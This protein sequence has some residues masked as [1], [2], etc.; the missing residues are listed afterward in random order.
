MGALQRRERCT[1]KA[2][3]LD[4]YGELCLI[5]WGIRYILSLPRFIEI[6]P[7]TLD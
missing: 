2:G 4:W 1:E 7:I 3:T 6:Y 5:R